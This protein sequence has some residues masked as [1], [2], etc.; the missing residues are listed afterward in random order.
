MANVIDAIIIGQLSNR[1]TALEGYIKKTHLVTLQ[2][3]EA[4]TEDDERINAL[5]D[6]VNALERELKELKQ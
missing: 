4:M 6:K 5:Q 1:V 2:L 3:M